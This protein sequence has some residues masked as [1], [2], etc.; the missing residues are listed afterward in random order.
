MIV[1]LRLE[2]ARVCDVRAGAQH[3]GVGPRQHVW[4]RVAVVPEVWVCV[5]DE[6]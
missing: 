3:A 5:H 6:Q 4:E 1:Q 2:H